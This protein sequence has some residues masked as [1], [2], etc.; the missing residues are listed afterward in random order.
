M[1]DKGKDISYLKKR[2][3]R[4]VAGWMLDGLFIFITCFDDLTRGCVSTASH[5]TVV[6]FAAQ[7]SAEM[8]TINVQ[9]ARCRPHQR[10]R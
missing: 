7:A 1:K 2:C 8:N 9:P 10:L 5:N 4:T 3:S 6:N